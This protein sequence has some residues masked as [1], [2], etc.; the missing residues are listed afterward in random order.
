[1]DP[2]EAQR[3]SSLEARATV[4]WPMRRLKRDA[5]NAGQLQCWGSAKTQLQTFYLFE[6]VVSCCWKLSIA[7]CSGGEKFVAAVAMGEHQKGTKPDDL[8]P[9]AKAFGLDFSRDLAVEA[10]TSDQESHDNLVPIAT[11]P[12]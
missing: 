9:S 7:E 2:S 8:P 4:L 5:G 3:G 11:P 10:Q 6:C 12:W 1:M